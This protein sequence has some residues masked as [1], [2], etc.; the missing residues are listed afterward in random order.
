[1]G[2]GDAAVR[3]AFHKRAWLAYPYEAVSYADEAAYEHAVVAFR[4]ICLAF[5]VL[6][7]RER[8]RIYVTS[9]FKGLQSSESF[10]EDSV[11]EADALDVYNGFFEG[12]DEADREYLL[13]NGADPPSEDEESEDNVI[14]LLGDDDDD[15]DDEPPEVL[16]S[17]L[18]QPPAS[19]NQHSAQLLNAALPR[20]PSLAAGSSVTMAVLPLA[21]PDAIPCGGVWTA[22]STR[23]ES[24]GSAPTFASVSASASAPVS[25]SLRSKH[26]IRP[27]ATGVVRQPRAMP[28]R[29]PL[30]AA[31]RLFRIG[32]SSAVLH[33]LRHWRKGVRR[34][35]LPKKHPDVAVGAARRRAT[36]FQ[37]A[38]NKSA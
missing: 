7:D 29:L 6:K 37:P 16:S 30:R 14:G 23:T 27:G 28:F 19:Q 1:M 25:A 9:G 8:R 5:S 24:D 31:R 38:I 4:R 15:D 36:T 22:I 12:T 26:F 18:E 2:G 21:G 11:F 34:V 10:Q 3:T 35:N 32:G 33:F 13:L 20:P 17:R